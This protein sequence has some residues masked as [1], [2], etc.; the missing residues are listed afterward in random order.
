MLSIVPD[1]KIPIMWCLTS[2]LNGKG[3]QWTSKK[4]KIQKTD[5]SVKL[6]FGQ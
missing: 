3:R 4:E 5:F 2:I 6:E 1:F